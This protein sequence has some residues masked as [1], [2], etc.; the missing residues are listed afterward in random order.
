MSATI[1]IYACAYNFMCYNNLTAV[2]CASAWRYIYHPPSILLPIFPLM[3]KAQDPMLGYKIH[4]SEWIV[5]SKDYQKVMSHGRRYVS[6][7]FVILGVASECRRAGIIVSKKVGGSVQRHRVKR[8]IKEC[9]R[10]LPDLMVPSKQQQWAQQRWPALALVIIARKSASSA[11][12]HHMASDLL[13][14]LLGLAT[15][16]LRPAPE[17]HSRHH[18]APAPAATQLRRDA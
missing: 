2:G 1:T 9:Y 15:K 5:K 11:S 14:G 6:T 18:L 17:R 3:P 8:R 16:V 13:K 7:Y 12:Y 10:H 4:S